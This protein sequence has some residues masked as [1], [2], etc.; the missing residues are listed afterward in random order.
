MR[1]QFTNFVSPLVFPCFYIY[2]KKYDK[3]DVFSTKPDVLFSLCKIFPETQ[4]YYLF[5][6]L[7]SAKKVSLLPRARCLNSRFSSIFHRRF[8]HDGEHLI[9]HVGISA[10]QRDAAA[11]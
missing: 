7:N 11:L 8:S 1:I 5:Y 4:T 2:W 9:M 6:P 10:C 3:K